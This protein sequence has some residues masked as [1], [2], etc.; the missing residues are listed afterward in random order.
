MAGLLLL[1]VQRFTGPFLDLI[2]DAVESL[3]AR[4]AS[5]RPGREEA[6]KEAQA[7]ESAAP[8]A[9]LPALSLEAG[10]RKRPFAFVEERDLA[11]LKLLLGHQEIETT[12]VVMQF[13]PPAMASEILAGLPPVGR[14]QVVSMMSKPAVL[15]SDEVTGIE[16]TLRTQLDY[17]MGGEEKLLALVDTASPSLQAAI[18]EDVSKSDP[19]LAQRLSKRVVM[20]DDLMLLDEAGFKALGRAIPMQ[21][22]A[23]AIQS[24]ETLRQS[25]LSRLHGGLAE[26]LAQEVELMG[27]LPPAVLEERKRQVVAAL[28]KLVREGRVSISKGRTPPPPASP[29][30]AESAAPPAPAA[31]P[32]SAKPQA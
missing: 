31:S 25:V 32:E 19:A 26:W 11:S 20:L 22:L 6:E 24:S 9:A 29:R 17:L 28:T 18:L 1:L 3:K 14:K 21:S 16:D 12:A 8:A 13:L 15:D 5:A 30:P 10:G 23:A 2:K 4:A 7:A 27:T